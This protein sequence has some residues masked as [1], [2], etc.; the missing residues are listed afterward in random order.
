MKL[1]EFF[2]KEFLDKHFPK[3]CLM[4]CDKMKL[5]RNIKSKSVLNM[6]TETEPVGPEEVTAEPETQTETEQ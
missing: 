4:E 5:G 1:G 2:T 6:D 3:N